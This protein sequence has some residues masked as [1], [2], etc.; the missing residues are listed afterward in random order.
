MEPGF[1][2][3][4]ETNRRSK[5]DTRGF[6]KALSE[7]DSTEEYLRDSNRKLVSYDLRKIDWSAFSNRYEA[8]V[9]ISRVAHEISSTEN[10][11]LW[12]ERVGFKIRL[13]DLGPRSLWGATQILASWNGAS[14]NPLPWRCL[15]YILGKSDHH[16]GITA[17]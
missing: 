3:D 16:L 5:S 7:F 15:E 9:W 14:D 11:A 12:L 2:R 10:L 8:V 17:R 4:E 6:S 13:K 1:S